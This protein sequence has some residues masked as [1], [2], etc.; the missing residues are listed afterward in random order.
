MSIKQVTSYD[1]LEQKNLNGYA[2]SKVIATVQGYVAEEEF[3]DIDG[4]V[5]G[6]F[7]Y[8]HYDPDYPFQGDKKK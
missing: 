3:Y 6:Y 7:A 8:G 2:T 5:V 1:E 4:N